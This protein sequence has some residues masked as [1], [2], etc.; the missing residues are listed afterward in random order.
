[1]SFKML[2]KKERDK[3]K[4]KAYMDRTMAIG[5]ALLVVRLFASSLCFPIYAAE[6]GPV[7]DFGTFYNTYTSDA[8]QE[9]FTVSG[10][11]VEL[12]G[13]A[14][15]AG[16]FSFLVTEQ[17]DGSFSGKK[18]GGFSATVK[19]AADGSIA[20]SAI[21]YDA[22][23][24]YNYTIVEVIPT[25]KEEG[26]TYDTHRYGVTVTVTDDGQGSLAAEVTYTSGTPVFSNIYVPAGPPTGDSSHGA[27]FGVI[28]LAAAAICVGAFAVSRRRAR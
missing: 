21:T 19:N 23:G 16:E 1:M 15:E 24:E 12:D 7:I 11:K 27:L 14:M 26:M 10:L 28:A 8:T 25:E 4:I 2:S 13:K 6:T 20:F 9:D 3:K 18:D 22:A 17:A 5:G